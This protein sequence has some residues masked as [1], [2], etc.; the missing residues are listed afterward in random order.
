MRSYLENNGVFFH[1]SPLKNLESIKE[2]GIKPN[3]KGICVLRTNN[4]SIIN[5]VINSQLA[6]IND[7]DSYIIVEITIPQD[8]F[9]IYAYEPDILD[10]TDWTWP[11]HNNIKVPN[12]PPELITNIY[13]HVYDLRQASNDINN[14]IQ[15]V[16]QDW[17]LESFSI[18]YETHYNMTNESEVMNL[19]FNKLVQAFDIWRVLR[20]D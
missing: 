4:Q 6:N 2:Q 8:Y 7:G 11:L 19:G 17:F 18:I 9:P 20:L 16:N 10:N 12:V 13:H 3:N 15:F 1:I 14:Q 5:S